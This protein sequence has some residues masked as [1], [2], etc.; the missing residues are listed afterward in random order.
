[1]KVKVGDPISPAGLYS[2]DS[3]TFAFFVNPKAAIEEGNQPLY[4][5]IFMS[6][7]ELGEGAFKITQF[8]FQGVCGNHIVWDVKN[9]TEINYRHVGSVHQ[10]IQAAFTAS[11][12]NKMLGINKQEIV[13]TLQW[14]RNNRLGETMEE[15]VD[16]VYSMRLG[17]AITKNLLESSIKNAF[18][19]QLVEQDG[20]PFTFL[21]L[22]NSVTR[23]SQT[24][25]NQDDRSLVD[26]QIS[27]MTQKAR[28]LATV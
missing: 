13:N 24:L 6:N 11:N 26:T 9:V 5:G 19:M 8:L 7:S 4:Q 23:F 12:L 17:G 16:S 18:N 27:K 20:D 1:M 3:N 28:K 25:P 2:G 10:R 22:M 21:G 15:T 14:M